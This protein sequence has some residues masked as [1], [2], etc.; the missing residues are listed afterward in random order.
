MNRPPELFIPSKIPRAAYPASKIARE[1]SFPS[2]AHD[3]T[4]R[5]SEELLWADIDN[6]QVNLGVGTEFGKRSQNRLLISIFK[7]F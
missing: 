7:I 6:L 5:R 2:E 1:A 3:E 4:T